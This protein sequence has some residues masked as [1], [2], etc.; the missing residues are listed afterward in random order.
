MKLYPNLV[1]AVVGAL[2]QIFRERKYA[3]KVIQKTLKLDK[4]WGARD[5][6]FIAETTY[7]IVRWYRWIYELRGTPPSSKEDWWE[8][9]GIWL[10]WQNISLPNWKEFDSLSPSTITTR[11][12]DL[13]ANRAISA[14][15][16]EWL[17]EMASTELQEQ[18]PPTLSA[19][20]RTAPLVIRT[21]TL[22]TTR[23]KL[24]K[25]LQLQDI[26]SK[27][28]NEDALIIS[29]RTNLFSLDAFKKGLF[30]IQD[31]GSQQIAPFLE[32]QPGMQVIDACAGAGGKTL[33]LAALMK[34]K[35]R[36]LALDIYNWK[37][38]ELRRRAT[39]AGCDLIETRLINNQK[40]I[41]RLKGK[42]D[43]LL[44]D[45]PCSGLG[46]LKRNPDAKWKLNPVYLERV[47]ATQQQILETYPVMLKKGGLL[48]YATCSIL[49]T[50]NQ[51]QV[52]RFLS[53]HKG[54]FTLV[55]EQQLLPQEGFDGFY[56][57]L[58]RKE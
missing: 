17:D 11:A 30:E 29:K 42:A 39:R 35:G 19:L 28:Y 33:H 1:R 14:S 6:K 58:I 24:Q 57:A 38:K 9:V 36:I 43:R 52:E 12:S 32:I 45:V 40:V 2:E 49:P 37:L 10:L 21:N 22:K 5:R 25:S 15:I 54:Q 23:S 3:D 51:Q 55:K 26:S 50:E 46:V 13:Q 4:R 41:K 31:G 34:N 48:V 53:Q 7:E 18:W 20:N 56:M 27:K 8:M 44:L 47:K 16:P